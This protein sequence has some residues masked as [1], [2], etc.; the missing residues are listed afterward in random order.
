MNVIIGVLI[1]LLLPKKKTFICSGK[2]CKI[3]FS[4]AMGMVS[5]KYVDCIK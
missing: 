4:F 3:Y 1:D 5:D 2:F